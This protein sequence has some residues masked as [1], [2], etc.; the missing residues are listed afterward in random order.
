MKPVAQKEGEQPVGRG[1]SEGD[2]DEQRLK[3]RNPQTDT[4]RE[5]LRWPY[6]A[7]GEKLTQPLAEIFPH[8]AT[9]LQPLIT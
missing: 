6:R 2:K 8:V 3:Q 5:A 9:Y 1:T 4:K 7:T